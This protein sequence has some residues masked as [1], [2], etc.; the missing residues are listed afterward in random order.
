M[1]TPEQTKAVERLHDTVASRSSFG[2]YISKLHAEQL[3]DVLEQAQSK[4]DRLQK[5]ND[6]LKKAMDHRNEI[7]NKAHALFTTPLSSGQR[8]AHIPSQCDP[9]GF[10][11]VMREAMELMSKKQPIENP[12]IFLPKD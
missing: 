7:E 6:L 11:R 10:V 8:F 1:L 5:E 2:C 3:V 12:F 9:L 4:V